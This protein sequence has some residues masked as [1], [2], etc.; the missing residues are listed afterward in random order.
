MPMH[1]VRVRPT[2]IARSGAPSGERPRR[3]I[4]TDA[5]F[6][7][8]AVE[9]RCGDHG[10]ETQTEVR[11]TVTPNGFDGVRSEYECS[12][13]GKRGKLTSSHRL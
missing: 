8:G 3:A 13:G 9:W 10:G 12:A 4:R 7:Y 6:Q 2:R 1:R 5:A 11:I